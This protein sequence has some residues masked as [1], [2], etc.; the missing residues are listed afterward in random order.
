MIRT[1]SVISGTPQ[2]GRQQDDRLYLAHP[3]SLVHSLHLVLRL[4]H[5][6]HSLHRDLL[7]HHSLRLRL[8]H[9]HRACSIWRD[10]LHHEAQAQIRSMATVQDHRGHA[11]SRI[12]WRDQMPPVVAAKCERT[13]SMRQST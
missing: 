1:D 7:H 5:G 3:D 8:L 4:H 10:Q 6:L 13:H 11:E 9:H 12:W 2:P